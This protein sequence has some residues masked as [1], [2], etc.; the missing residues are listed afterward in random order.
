MTSS[1]VAK[2]VT[3][4]PVAATTP[5]RSLP[6]P[7]QHLARARHRG[8]HIDHLEDVD[9]AVLVEPYCLHQPA[10]VLPRPVNLATAPGMPA[11][12]RRNYPRSRSMISAA[13]SSAARR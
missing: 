9:V 3:P 1:P 4:P 13:G 5:A 12:R 7:D 8:R 2:P 6:C 11:W 10:S